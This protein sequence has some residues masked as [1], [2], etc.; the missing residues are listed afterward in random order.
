M[1]TKHE[2]HCLLVFILSVC[3]SLQAQTVFN[4]HGVRY[5]SEIVG[6]GLK[7]PSAMVF[8][9]D[10]HALVVERQSAKLDLLD[11]N[12]GSLT[13]LEGGFEALIGKDAG[14]HDAA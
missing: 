1:I 8:L 6:T 12:S 10:G 3:S 11:V 5:Q 9:P 2:I 7:Q 13:A 14:V 4:A